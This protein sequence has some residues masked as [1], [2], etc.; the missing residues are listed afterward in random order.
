MIRTAPRL[1]ASPATVHQDCYCLNAQRAAR[2]LA[3]LYDDGLR[4]FHLN[5][6]QFS[7]LMLVAGL[8]PVS[9]GQVAD[10]LVMDRTTVTAAVK[11]LERRGLLRAAASSA[12]QRQ[13]LLSLT[14]SGLVLLSRASI[15]WHKL[16]QT[17]QDHQPRATVR[18][19]LRR[20]AATA[21]VAS[22]R[23]AARQT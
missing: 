3:R 19:D 16:Q 18:A 20:L 17:V 13:R 14:P 7:L 9:M 1:A 8:Q 10:E 12:D 2:R 22:T 21:A 4:P 11:P 23:A 15:Q 5:H 6:G